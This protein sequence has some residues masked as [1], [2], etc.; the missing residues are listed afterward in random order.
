MKVVVIGIGNVLVADDGVGIRAVRELKS[1]VADERVSFA[2]IECGGFDLLD[3]LAGCDNAIIID[4]MRTDCHSPGSVLGFAL[5]APFSHPS[6]SSLHTIGLEGILAFGCAVGISLPS[7]VMV[8]GVEGREMETF[9]APM[10]PE[11]DSALPHL[12]E[13]VLFRLRDRMPGVR[14]AARTITESIF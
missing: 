13:A 4:A 1:I 9:G 8:L 10:T 12:V 3:L 6:S 5:H 11:V 2:E 7:E 14:L